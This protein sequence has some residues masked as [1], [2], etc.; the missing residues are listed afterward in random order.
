MEK[1]EQQSLITLFLEIMPLTDRLVLAK[2]QVVG[3]AGAGLE[4]FLDREKTLRHGIVD[5]LEGSNLRAD[6]LA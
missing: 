5:M 6:S 1:T 3:C 4:L 2:F